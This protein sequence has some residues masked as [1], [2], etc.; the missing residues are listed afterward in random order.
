MV[1]TMSGVFKG[2][3]VLETLSL[4]GDMFSALRRVQTSNDHI[5]SNS[6]PTQRVRGG[7]RGRQDGAYCQHHSQYLTYPATAPTRDKIWRAKFPRT[8]TSPAT[9][10][11]ATKAPRHNVQS[12]LPHHDQAPH[13]QTPR[14]QTPCKQTPCDPYLRLPVLFLRLLLAILSL[15]PSLPRNND[16]CT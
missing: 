16:R 10:L 13:D 1:Y 15:S 6:T 14:Y 9:N 2:S 3:E 5:G 8:H 7:M 4:K 11:P 12:S